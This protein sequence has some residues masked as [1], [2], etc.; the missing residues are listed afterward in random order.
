MKVKILIGFVHFKPD[1]DWIMAQEGQ[2]IE[3]PEGADW[4]K[5]GIAVK[6]A[7]IHPS[8]EVETATIQPGEISQPPAARRRAKK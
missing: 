3:M 1:G 2:I 6:V 4:I 7:N 8:K 5:K